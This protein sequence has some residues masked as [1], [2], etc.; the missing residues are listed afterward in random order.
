MDIKYLRLNN[1]DGDICLIDS[2]T[3]HT[4]FKNKGYF[5]YLK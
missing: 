3:M 4:I 5:S 2:R 1:G